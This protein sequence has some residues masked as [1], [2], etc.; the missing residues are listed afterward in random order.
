MLA[1]APIVL[2]VYVAADMVR[3]HEHHVGDVLAGAA[4]GVC[5]SVVAFWHVFGGKNVAAGEG[6]IE[7]SITAEERV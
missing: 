4:I 2:A 3:W 1:L 5:T 6:T 7:T